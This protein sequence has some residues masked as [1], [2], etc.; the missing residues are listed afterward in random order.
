M[1]TQALKEAVAAQTW[2]GSDDRLEGVS[3][4]ATLMVVMAAA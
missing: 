2:R 4:W 1:D 3:L